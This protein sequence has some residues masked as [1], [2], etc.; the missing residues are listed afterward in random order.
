MLWVV[1]SEPSIGALIGLGA[2]GLIAAIGGLTLT[3]QHWRRSRR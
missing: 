2:A 3:I 1:D